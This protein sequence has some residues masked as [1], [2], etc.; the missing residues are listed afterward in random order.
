VSKV[1]NNE[2]QN[3]SDLL[4]HLQHDLKWKVSRIGDDYISV[5]PTGKDKPI[6]LKVPLLLARQTIENY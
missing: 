4:R 5:I 2:I 6:R 3:R 1:K